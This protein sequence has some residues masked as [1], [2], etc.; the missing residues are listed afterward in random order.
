MEEKT[1]E[2]RTSRM[3]KEVVACFQS[4]VLKN[5]FAVLFEDGHNKEISDSSLLYVCDKEDT[6]EEVDKT[7]FDLPK[8]VQGEFITINGYPFFKVY[9]AFCKVMYFSVFYC[10]IFVEET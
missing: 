1:R 9:E 4:I 5:N 3:S 2:V 8:I 7:I 10:L 6:G